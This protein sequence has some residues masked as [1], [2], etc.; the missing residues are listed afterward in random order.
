LSLDVFRRSVERVREVEALVSMAWGSLGRPGE[1]FQA[2]QAAGRRAPAA[3][4]VRCKSF[5]A[6]RLVHCVQLS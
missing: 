1:G 2:A 4:R 6:R 3:V 5:F